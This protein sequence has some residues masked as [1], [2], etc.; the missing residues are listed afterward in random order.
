MRRNLLTIIIPVYNAEAYLSQCLDSMLKQD[1]D[2]FE[3]I[4]V[5]DGSTDGSPGICLRY[6]EKDSRFR[7]CRQDNA[8]PGTAR[9]RGM[10]M[11]EGEW[12]CFVD[13]DDWIAP[14]YVSQMLSVPADVDL[15][16][17]NA[18]ML[19]GYE[20]SA[21]T[22]ETEAVNNAYGPT[23][24]IYSM[25]IGQSDYW[26]YAYPWNKRYRHDLICESGLCFSADM[27][28]GED[29]AFVL[30]YLKHCQTMEA[31]DSEIYHYRLRNGLS[32]CTP[33]RENYDALCRRI[34]EAADYFT[35]TRLRNYFLIRCM[36]YWCDAQHKH[37]CSLLQAYRE[38]VGLLLLS[39]EAR[40]QLL[41]YAKSNL[42]N[43][44]MI[45]NERT[46]RFISLVLAD[47]D[48]HRT[49]LRLQWLRFYAW[50]K[51]TFSKH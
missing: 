29:E 42:H 31:L 25:L 20:T 23:D 26:A 7:Y 12:I 51:N 36:T 14:S 28:M 35:D 17:V 39:V 5:D 50:Q 43:A 38:A 1:R 19:Q 48:S 18:T 47:P 22:F 13:A 34:A 44:N 46:L 2:N 9:N 10:E 32:A 3:V 45:R 30:D 4:M 6:Q 41:H 27:K 11:A 15:V 40:T 33:R 21:L 24:K 8:G 49:W 37:A 16:L